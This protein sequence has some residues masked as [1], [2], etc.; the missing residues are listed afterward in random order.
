MTGTSDFMSG[1]MT[2]Q[3]SDR[4][5]M[6][7]AGGYWI[8]IILIFA[9]FGFGG[10]GWGNR[11]EQVDIDT[12]FLERDIFNTNQNVSNTA[13]QTQRDVLSSNDSLQRDVLENR[14]NAQICCCNTEKE[15][16]ENRYQNAL[17]T[18]TLSSQMSECCCGINKNIEAVRA[19]NYKNTCEITNAIHSEGELTRALINNNTMQD[20][21]DRL[22]ERDRD[23]QSANLQISQISQTNNIVNS[24]RPVPQPAYLTCSPYFAYN[25]G[26]NGCNNG[27]GGCGCCNL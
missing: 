26:F 2:G 14:Y 6:Y 7:G 24:L 3:N 9:L 20:L 5:D 8:W 16:L 18:Q 15:V 21:R 11:N 1:F 25:Y 10:N 22:N 17:Q 12:R 23:L 13:C 4:G 19:E 27:C